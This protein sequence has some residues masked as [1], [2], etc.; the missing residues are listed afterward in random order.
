MMKRCAKDN[1]ADEVAMRIQSDAL[2]WKQKYRN[3]QAKYCDLKA[4]IPWLESKNTVTRK[5]EIP[6]LS[7]KSTV[8]MNAKNTVEGKLSSWNLHIE[9]NFIVLDLQK[10]PWRSKKYRSSPIYLEMPWLFKKIP[11]LSD[12]GWDL[13]ETCI[14]FIDI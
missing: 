2:T 6:W 9:S 4:K 14:F 1:L 3:L 10:K 5:P 7:W 13:R 12:F 11:W 8:G